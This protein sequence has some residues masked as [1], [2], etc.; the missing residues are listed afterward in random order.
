MKWD[1]ITFAFKVLQKKA[2][3]GIN[4]IDPAERYINKR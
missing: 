1:L 4:L 3:Q 2:P